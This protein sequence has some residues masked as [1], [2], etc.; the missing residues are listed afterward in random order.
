VWADLLRHTTKACDGTQVQITVFNFTPA[1]TLSLEKKPRYPVDKRLCGHKRQS[2]Y[3]GEGKIKCL[4]RESNNDSLFFQPV[5]KSL[6]R[7]SNSSPLCVFAV[8]N[9]W[10]GSSGAFGEEDS[11][12]LDNIEV[13]SC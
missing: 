4:F 13:A 5:S 3:F 1:A 6:Y 10:S 7:L 9:F 12:Y 8:D 11:E 2:R